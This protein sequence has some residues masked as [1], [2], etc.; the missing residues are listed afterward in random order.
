MGDLEFAFGPGE[1]AGEGH[2]DIGHCFVA[3]IFGGFDVVEEGVDVLGGDGF[4]L[5]VGA[6]VLIEAVKGQRV[7]SD[8]VGTEVSLA[9][10]PVAFEGGWEV[11]RVLRAGFQA[12]I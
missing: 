8:G 10:D 9:G 7:V 5:G 12:I 2:P 3:E 6:N 11:H 4:D 1:E